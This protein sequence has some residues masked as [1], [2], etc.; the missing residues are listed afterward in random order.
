MAD[1]KERPAGRATRE[2]E[3]FPDG[4]SANYSSSIGAEQGLEA[5]G[6][7]GRMRPPRPNKTFA[8]PARDI[9]VYAETDVLVVGGGPGGTAAAVAAARMGADVLLVERYGHLGGL[10]TGGLVIWIDRM[11][12]WEGRQVITGVADD[13]IEHLWEGAV[14]GPA[15][16]RWGSHDDED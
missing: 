5:F 11:T 8:E 7:R 3:I 12:D 16:D 1:D 13:L 10:S 6:E 14:F 9:P 4:P 2:S 15:R